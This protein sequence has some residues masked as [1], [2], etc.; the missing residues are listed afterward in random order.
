MFVQ[1]IKTLGVPE[2]N[3]V[4]HFNLNKRAKY[5]L[6]LQ[7]KLR[8]RFRAEYLGAFL[9]RPE[10]KRTAK[11]AVRD[12][13]LIGADNIKHINWA[14]GKVIEIVPGR[15]GVTRLV[16]L[17]TARD[18][19]IRPIERLYPLDSRCGTDPQPRQNTH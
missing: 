17:Q 10:N 1:D 5:R 19:L 4:D 11:I 15:E 14:L 7:K 18:E 3:A 8:K 2:C 13:F 12:V 9:Q 6:I 16:K